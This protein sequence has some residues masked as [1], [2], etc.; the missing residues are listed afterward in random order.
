MQ[1]SAPSRQ[2][3][4]TLIRSSS[5]SCPPP[6]ER[7]SRSSLVIPFYPAACLFSPPQNILRGAG[8]APES[9]V[10]RGD[11]VSA[12]LDWPRT[13]RGLGEISRVITGT[14]V[15]PCV[16]DEEAAPSCMP[17]TGSSQIQL[18]IVLAHVGQNPPVHFRRFLR[19]AKYVV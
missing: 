2:S 9:E 10:T 17:A 1:R 13:R 19:L 7:Q 16:E 5:T 3:N 14:G 15:L 18:I 6:I 11:T 12:S 8:Q 4:P